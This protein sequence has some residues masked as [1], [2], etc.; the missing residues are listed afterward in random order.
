MMAVRRPPTHHAQAASRP[1]SFDIL[2]VLAY[3]L[4]L[5]LLLQ[6]QSWVVPRT[7]LGSGIGLVVAVMFVAF[8]IA[9]YAANMLPP[10]AHLGPVPKLLLPWTILVTWSYLVWSCRGLPQLSLLANVGYAQNIA[11]VIFTLALGGVLAPRQRYRTFVRILVAC[12][13]LYGLLL[14]ITSLV[15]TEVSVAL[16][17]PLLQATDALQGVENERGGFIRPQGMAGHPLEAGVIATVLTPLAISL[18]RSAR[19]RERAVWW[20]CAGALALG[21]L[22][23]LSRSATVGLAL[24]IMVMSLRWPR[25][26]IGNT[27]LAALLGLGCLVVAAPGRF[28]AYADLF[29]LSSATD[30]SLYSRQFARQQAFTVIRQ[31]FWAGRGVSSHGALG[32][33]TLDNQLLGFAVEQG[34]PL[35]LAFVLLLCVPGWWLLHRAP[36]LPSADRELAG[37]LAGSL[38]ALLLCSAILDIFG[39]PQIR[40]LVFLLLALVGPVAAGAPAVDRQAPVPGDA[41]PSNT[42]LRS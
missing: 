7:G 40:L 8:A 22:S 35:M 41:A 14:V 16:K 12:G 36:A 19:G 1:G 26:T 18:A 5:A 21:S 17:L 4:P 6:R 25:R 38:A 24:A 11:E 20:G 13:A 39:F 42:Q 3:A 15:G 27:V 10:S 37:G 33:R 9:G 31:H 34:V 28:A 29:S 32:G 30:S 23:T 2:L